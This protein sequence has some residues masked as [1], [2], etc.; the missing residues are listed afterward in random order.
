VS[1][2]EGLGLGENFVSSRREGGHRIPR[3]ERFVGPARMLLL[4]NRLR[5][6]FMRVMSE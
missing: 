2:G 6:S 5:R 1:A 3:K 4:E